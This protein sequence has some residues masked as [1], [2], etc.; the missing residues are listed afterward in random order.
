V[1]V[2]LSIED[3]QFNPTLTTPAVEKLRDQTG[4]NLLTGMIGT[5][6]GL[7]VRDSL[8]RDC[9]PQL[10]NNSGDPRWGQAKQF[11][12]SMGVLAPYNTET[13]IYVEDIKTKFPNGTTAAVFNVNSDFGQDYKDTFQKLAPDA[14]VTIVDTQT[15]EGADSS[16]PTSQVT[17]I[18]S[19]KPEVILA[20]PLGAQCI[21]F[22]N[23]L[24]NAKATT[25]GWNPR[26]Y[27]TATCASTL[28]LALSGAAADGIIT[29]VTGIDV[30]DPK[31][32]AVPTVV[33]YKAVMAS[34]APEVTD[35]AT[36][37]AG[38]TVGE[39]TVEVLKQAAASP[40][41][42]T[43]A[44]IMNAARNLSYHPSLVREGITFKASG[45][46]D[47]YLNEVQQVVQYNATSKTYTEIGSLITKFEGKTEVP[48]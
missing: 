10:F 43:R 9:V 4:V 13:A 32:A 23:E 17:S 46:T 20:V 33:S 36:A 31:N 47:P 1:K 37:G 27:I 7:A 11:P 2:E 44:S 30:A 21:S 3:D 19:K 26:V 29:V 22:L 5:A 16:P 42:L 41:G 40:D 28:L 25:T 18:A 39:L 15:I 34:A 24:A 35:I 6:N 45:E 8:N 38:W 48:A 14:K 12:W